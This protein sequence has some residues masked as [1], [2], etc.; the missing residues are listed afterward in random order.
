[1]TYGELEPKIVFS[2]FKQLSD[3]PRG[4][5]NERAAAEFVRDTA[6]SLGH[7]AEI[8]G[9]NNVFI[10]AKAAPGYEDHP[11]MMLQGHLDMVC[12]ANRGTVH[13][14]LTDPIEL[15]LTGDELRA[16]GTTLGADDGIAAAIIL[17]ILSSPDLP[18]PALECLF[19][20]E[21]ETGLNGMRSFDAAKAKARRLINLDCAGE[22][23]ATVSCAGGV[24]SHIR[25]TAERTSLADPAVLTLEVTGLAGGHSGED[26]NLGRKNAI[27]TLTRILYAASK[28]S[29]FRLVS[30]AGGNRDNAIPRECAAT[31]SPAD[32]AAFRAAA[33][34]EIAAIAKEC[35]QDDAGFHAVFGTDRAESA[36]TPASTS[37]FLFLLSNLPNGVHAMSRA[38]PG[39][40]ETSS[41]LAVVR[42]CEDGFEIVVSSRS[43]VESM[44]DWMQNRVECAAGPAGA[45][46]EHV[47][48]Y[49]GW[50]YVEGSPMQALYLETWKECFGTDA[51]VVGI[52]A[53]LECGLLKGK[54][55]DMDMISIG[56]DIRNLHSP[57]EVLYVGSLARMYTLVCA[58]L[59]KA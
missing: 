23:V 56:A 36:L 54:I 52:H 21:E 19:T 47:S 5:G 20:T 22:G 46:V 1:M 14:F 39:L 2:Y 11:P 35:V 45:A 12:E 58:M 33:E 7:E 18:H 24:R 9:A 3:I 13:D 38:V 49:P 34:S 31:V 40:V 32:P 42:A 59:R 44:L 55:P 16:N 30:F 4:S 41:N 15:I 10:R 48:R 37:S 43:S 25:F 51:G 6:L 17:A 28:A 53:G 26:I 27:V 57:D 50:D 8:D 29:P